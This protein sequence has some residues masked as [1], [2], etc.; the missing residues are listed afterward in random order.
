MALA[1]GE[2]LGPSEII[3]LIGRGDMGEVYRAR[4]SHLGRDVAIKVSVERFT[5][6]FDREA[7]VNASLNHPNISTLPDV[8]PNYLVIELVEGETLAER[9]RRGAL[10]FNEALKIARQVADALE[11]AHEKGITHRDLKPGNIKI[12]PDG[13]VKVLDF[14]LAKTGGTPAILWEDSPTMAMGQTQ[15]GVILRTA[16]YMSPEQAKGKSVDKSADICVRRR[17]VRN[18]GRTAVV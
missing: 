13:T 16:T 2:K 6:R 12:K 9:I 15:A 4:D 18:A 7:C 11:A 5:D 14:G 1:T 17:A 3:E 8:G 10:P